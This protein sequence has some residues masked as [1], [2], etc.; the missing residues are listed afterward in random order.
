LKPEVDVLPVIVA[1]KV[2]GCPTSGLI[3]DDVKVTV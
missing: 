2:T 1:L 3:G